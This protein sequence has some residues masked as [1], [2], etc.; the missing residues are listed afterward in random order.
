M[1]ILA[2]DF[3]TADFGRDSAC[4]LGLAMIE[5]GQITETQTI[6]IRPPRRYFQFTY[7]HGITWEDVKN[8]P[9]FAEHW[10]DLAGWFE[11]ADFC[12]AHNAPFDRGVLR[13]CCE[14]AGIA[15]PPHPF[16]CTVRLARKLWHLKPA[17]LPNVC[18]H[19]GIP[20]NHHDAGSD[21]LACAT[22][23]VHALNTLGNGASPEYDTLRPL[24]LK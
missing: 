19:F 4:A 22:I 13:S 24:A 7:I 12:V 15:P 11:R 17:A 6:L 1:N 14:Q 3:E 23:M 18:S 10:E 5:D 16:L 20:L 2:L 21:T 9:T 8:K